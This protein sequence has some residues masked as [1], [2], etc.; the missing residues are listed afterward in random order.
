MLL[1]SDYLSITPSQA[2][3]QWSQVLR[4]HPM[5][6]GVRQE[7][8]LPIETLLCFGLGLV[9]EP[10]PS[11]NV[12]LRE[13]SSE[14]I[15]IASLVRRPPTSLAAK[16]AN[17]QGRQ[18]HGAKYEQQLFIELSHDLPQYEFLYSIVMEAARSIGL[19]VMD[20]PDILGL[21]E[22]SL[23]SVLQADRVTA[24][25]IHSAVDDEVH[26]RYGDT[27]V[28]DDAVTERLLVGKIRIGQQQF[29]RQVLHNYGYSCAFCGLNFRKAGLPSSRMLV[30]GH[31]KSW[32]DS[33]ASERTDSSNGIAACPTHDAAFESHLVSINE[34]LGI[35]LGMR[36][37]LT[38][39]QNSQVAR[40]FSDA[41]IRK[42]LLIPEGASPPAEKFL[43][44]HRDLQRTKD[45]E[46]SD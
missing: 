46:S 31:I 9:A 25:Q 7:D 45:V 13:S 20:L 15:S 11:G 1:L 23:R 35:Q 2:R 16:L 44:W 32:K 19:G 12:N 22:Y 37:R 42:S 36:L 38:L 18:T 10:S 39:S 17:L 41:G 21:E 43:S 28:I 30:A 24:E 5:P 3:A 6:A 4:R 27:A 29:A 26:Q 33:T 14:V 40:N 8:F 34:D